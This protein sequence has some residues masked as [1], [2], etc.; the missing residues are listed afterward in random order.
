MQGHNGVL[1][2]AQ[3][4]WLD[5]STARFLSLDPVSGDLSEP[6]STQGFSY[7]RSSPTRFTDPDGRFDLG[8]GVT[9]AEARV[10][11]D[12]DLTDEDYK[13]AQRSERG[14]AGGLFGGLIG[15]TIP[16]LPAWA[17]GALFSLGFI[18]GVA[19]DEQADLLTVIPGLPGLVLSGLHSA[20]KVDEILKQKEEVEAIIASLDPNSPDIEELL[21]AREE[22]D[23]AAIN[24]AGQGV[25]SALTHV[26]VRP[27]N[28]PSLAR[29]R[30]QRTREN[31]QPAIDPEH[32]NANVRIVRNGEV[33]AKDRIRSGVMVP[34]EKALGGRRAQMASHTEA[35]GS[36]SIEPESGDQV[37]YVG[38]LP[39]CTNCQG[40][41]R[42]STEG[43][44]HQVQYRWREEGKSMV[45]VYDNGVR[46]YKGKL[47][48]YAMG[49]KK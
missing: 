45:V 17:Q 28:I 39:P 34:E 21:A 15:L 36:R 7:G 16:L 40:S 4:R 24:A 48:D 11:F 35:R 32:H 3:Q 41:M 46:T 29:F 8:Y 20:S 1:L 2:Y 22:L 19:S 38:Q 47:V 18:A 9:A 23:E 10:I 44:G 37:I 25:A 14:V 13:N 26:A 6:L 27:P 12:H 49:T 5:P 30:N 33:V 31:G 43:T 42:R